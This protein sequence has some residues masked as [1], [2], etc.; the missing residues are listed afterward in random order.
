[1][2]IDGVIWYGTQKKSWPCLG[3]SVPV[4]KR[5]KIWGWWDG[6]GAKTM[7]STGTG[8][9]RHRQADTDTDRHRHRH[10]HRHRD[11]PRVLPSQGSQGNLPSSTTYSHK[12][13]T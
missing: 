13:W 3:M 4:E 12:L 9:D 8:T 6:L 10:R 11:Q 7:H 1:M 5:A 2:S